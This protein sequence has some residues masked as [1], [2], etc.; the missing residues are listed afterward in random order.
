MHYSIAEMFDVHIILVVDIGGTSSDESTWLASS[1][2]FVVV[3]LIS[4]EG[5]CFLRN[6]VV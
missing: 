1:G 5:H 2:V 6:D 4:E 3:D